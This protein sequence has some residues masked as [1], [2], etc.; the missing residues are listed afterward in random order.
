MRRFLA[1]RLTKVLL[2]AHDTIPLAA[3]RIV[4]AKTMYDPHAMCGTKSRTSIR[5]ER[6][7]VIKVRILRM[8][9]PRRYRG[10]WEGAWK[11]AA[12]AI[13]AMTRVN[14]AAIGCTTRIADRVALVSVDR[15][16]VS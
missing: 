15:S 9:I 4:A 16:K 14:S 7:E 13:T 1:F 11:W 10:E 3:I 2:I 6:S 8:K 5:N 12:A